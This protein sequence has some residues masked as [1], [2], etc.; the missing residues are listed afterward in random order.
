LETINEKK[1]GM[2]IADESHYI[3]NSDA[4][5]TQVLIPI[6]QEAKRTILLSG[7]ASVS[8]PVELYCQLDAL[9]FP[10]FKTLKKFANRYCAPSQV[11][12]KIL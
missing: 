2:I 9:G 10:V 4:K 6:L 5:R 12:S 3:K 1:F 8:A 7:T 11:S